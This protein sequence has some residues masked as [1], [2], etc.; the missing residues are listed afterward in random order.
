MAHV[1]VY[2]YV[3]SNNSSSQLTRFDK[4]LTHSCSYQ[5]KLIQI[6]VKQ[7]EKEKVNKKTSICI[8]I[9]KQWREIR[10]K[11]NRTFAS[12]RWEEAAAGVLKRRKKKIE[13]GRKNWK[14]RK[15]FSF[16]P[17]KLFI[18]LDI[19]QWGEQSTESTSKQDLTTRTHSHIE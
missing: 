5:V 4:N 12:M 2:L 16:L 3:F 10:A 19:Q 14:E 13:N 11:R 8:I 1:K 7:W 18:Y 6:D 17:N 9:G 15:H